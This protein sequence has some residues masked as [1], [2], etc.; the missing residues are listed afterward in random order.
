MIVTTTSRHQ[1]V[2]VQVR[3]GLLSYT[4]PGSLGVRGIHIQS[5]QNHRSAVSSL[6]Y[7]EILEAEAERTKTSLGILILG[8]GCWR[9]AFL[10]LL[11]CQGFL[12]KN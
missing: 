8:C 4:A 2:R 12:G 7:F 5:R 3:A 11:F 9:G 6:L 10:F 1:C